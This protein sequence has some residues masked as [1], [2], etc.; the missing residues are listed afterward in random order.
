[1]MGAQLK[2]ATLGPVIHSHYK[3]VRMR[4]LT[5]LTHLNS[6]KENH[7]RLD[8]KVVELPTR[9]TCYR[10]GVFRALAYLRNDV[11]WR[12]CLLT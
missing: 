4:I 11:S 7:Y 2:A 3:T 5:Y 1:M 6:I 12:I 9:C 8:L 10:T